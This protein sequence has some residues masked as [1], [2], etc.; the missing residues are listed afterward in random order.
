MRNY[1][2]AGIPDRE[3]GSL[4]YSQDVLI[5]YKRE[6]TSVGKYEGV[7]WNMKNWCRSVA[8]VL[9]F[10]ILEEIAFPMKAGAAGGAD[11]K[12]PA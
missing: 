8:V 9:L 5:K 12:V 11:Q 2:R 1:F 6:F 10:C 4:S 3:N 7:R